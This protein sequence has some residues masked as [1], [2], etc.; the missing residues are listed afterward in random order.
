MKIMSTVIVLGAKGRFGQAALKAFLAA[1][2]TVRTF[3]R[4]W[5]NPAPTGVTQI[6]GDAFD[7]ECLKEACKGC[8]VIVNAL[9]LPY[10]S[11]ARDLPRL[12]ANVIAAT[13]SSG[14]TV[15]IP[16]N[17]YVYGEKSDIALKETTA[18]RPTT[19]KG[20]LRVDMENA[21]RDAQVPTIVLRGGDYIGEGQTGNWFD[22]YITAKSERGKTMYPGPLD[23]VHAWAYLPDMAR[24]AVQL[25]EAR[26][27]CERFEEFGFH[28][29]ALTGRALVD[30]VSKAIGK[31]Q[32]VTG[33]PWFLLRFMGVFSPFMR[34]VVEMRYLWHVPHRMDGA[35]LARFLPDFKAT[36]VDDAI[37][38]ALLR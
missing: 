8:D 6:E 16:G 14:A 12:T 37:K 4:G 1:G 36:S 34:E 19:R 26:H 25:A 29:Y 35:K 18:W 33:M 2:W 10:E 11:W 22:G 23:Q 24:A 32:K 30:A 9:H 21:F 38:V 27:R 13:K 7:T 17:L 28:G 5:K 3:A 20:Q 31:P 15:L